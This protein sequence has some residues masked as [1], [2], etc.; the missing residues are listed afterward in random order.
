MT[1]AAGFGVV[2]IASLD[3]RRKP[4]HRAE[5]T[6]QLLLG[7]IV[8]LGRRAGSGWVS[9]ENERDG[10]SGWV[11]DWGIVPCSRARAARWAGLA[12]HRVRE[13]VAHATAERTGGAVV[14]PL[15]WNSVV[16]AERRQGGRS[17]VELPDGRRGWIASGVLAEHSARPPFLLDR[18]LSLMGVPYLWGGRTPAGFDCSGLVQQVLWEQGLRVPRDAAEQL[19]ASTPLRDWREAGPGDLAFFGVPGERVSHVGLMLGD[20][21]YLHARGMVR[22]A[23]LHRYNPLCDNQLLRQFRVAGK[24]GAE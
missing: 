16:I 12:R 11:R 17:R 4:E 15:F 10:Y 1:R 21:L 23:S 19:R 2:S 20:G 14:S 18:V 5:M 22:L 6:S 13:A 24:L 3:V 9:I 8:R 7:E